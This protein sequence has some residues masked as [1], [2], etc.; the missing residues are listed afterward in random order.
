M[1]KSPEDRFQS[2]LEFAEALREVNTATEGGIEPAT[3]DSAITSPNKSARPKGSSSAPRKETM[4]LPAPE[5][6][7]ESSLDRVAQRR[8]DAAIGAEDAPTP[9]RR[10]LA[11]FSKRSRTSIAVA[12]SVL[13][14]LLVVLKLRS[15]Q[16]EPPP[17]ADGLPASPNLESM[18][19]WDRQEMAVFDL[20]G[21]AET[22]SATT[23]VGWLPEWVSLPM[24]VSDPSERA[25]TP[26]AS[27][28]LEVNSD[29]GR[30]ATAE[31]SELPR[32]ADSRPAAANSE[33]SPGLRSPPT[34]KTSDPPAGEERPLAALEASA[35]TAASSTAP[36][37]A[38]AT[39]AEPSVRRE[40]S[41]ANSTKAVQG[42]TAERPAQPALAQLEV[43]F[44]NRLKEASLSVWIDEKKIWSQPMIAQ[45]NFLKRTIGKDVWT[46]LPLRAGKRVIDIRIIGA[47]GKIDLVKRIEGA[48]AR[49]EIKRLR[50][51]LTPWKKLRLEWK[52]RARG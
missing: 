11:A 7:T 37:P 52:D 27:A 10:P 8:E 48:F 1:E 14:V 26:A 41:G 40:P 16:S 47:E 34:A 3:A 30:P 17:T 33:S 35:P 15:W 39:G 29:A 20:P 36:R 12:L 43:L 4:I 32:T 49:G 28:S 6:G 24:A 2:G 22:P 45:K 25:D 38:K 5:E 19:Q 50:V 21:S 44:R 42:K 18:P 13:F 9:R 31:T 46:T 51:V 23:N